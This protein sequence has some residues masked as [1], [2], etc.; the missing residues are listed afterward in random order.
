MTSITW[1]DRSLYIVKVLGPN[2]AVPCNNRYRVIE[3]VMTV[4]GLR[5]RITNNS[6]PTFRAAQAFITKS[7]GDAPKKDQPYKL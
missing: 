7:G 6:F 5:D 3:K 2:E 4:D 1:T